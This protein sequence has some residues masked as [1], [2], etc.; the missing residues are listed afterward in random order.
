[1]VSIAHAIE[2]GAEGLRPWANCFRSTQAGPAHPTP[3]FPP[4]SDRRFAKLER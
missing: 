2:V 4:F 3:V 1:L